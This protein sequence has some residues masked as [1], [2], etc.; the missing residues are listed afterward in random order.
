MAENVDY[1]KELCALADS[2]KLKHAT[3]K[4][5]VTA[6]GVSADVKVI[7]LLSVPNQVKSQLLASARLLI[8]TPRNEHFGI[9]PLEAMLA[10]VPVLAANEGGPTETVVE[11]QTGWLRDV[12]DVSAW[13]E[14]MELVLDGSLSRS[15]LQ[16]M[17][18]RG[19][20][21]VKKLFSKEQMA[22]SLER[23]VIRKIRCTCRRIAQRM[24][25]RPPM[26]CGTIVSPRT[27]T[28]RVPT[29]DSSQSQPFLS[30]HH[31]I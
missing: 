6:L 20:Q 3:F 4:T 1:H 30:Q 8:Y 2:L 25:K 23:R 21:R 24:A 15:E 19:R 5:I 11:G 10:G 28:S 12:A 14:V 22:S 26:V 31:G 29:I 17:G 16:Q 9:V 7:F 18:Y 13:R 27:R